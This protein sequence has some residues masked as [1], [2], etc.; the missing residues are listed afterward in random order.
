MPKKWRVEDSVTSINAQTKVPQLGT[1]EFPM[2]DDNDVAG[3]GKFVSLVAA[4]QMVED[5]VD[6]NDFIEKTQK[7][8]LDFIQAVIDSGNTSLVPAGLQENVNKCKEIFDEGNDFVAGTYGKEV[9]LSLLSRTGCEGLRYVCCR[10]E[11]RNSIFLY[12]VGSSGINESHERYYQQK[13]AGVVIDTEPDPGSEVKGNGTTR[14]Q[15]KANQKTRNNK[16][17]QELFT[18]KDMFIL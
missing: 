13:K 8:V 7:S 3:F 5:Y 16:A 18:N 12:P 15:L 4:D 1:I 6:Q 10:Y 11:N 9:L 14:Q 2:A 17:A